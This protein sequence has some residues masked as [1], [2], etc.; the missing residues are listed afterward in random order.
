MKKLLITTFIFSAT[1]NAENIEIYDAKTFSS[2]LALTGCIKQTNAEKDP[3][4]IEKILVDK[5]QQKGFKDFSL[6]KLDKSMKYFSDKPDLMLQYGMQMMLDMNACIQDITAPS[7][8]KKA[9]KEF[10]RTKVL[11]LSKIQF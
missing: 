8:E 1:V 11:L 9:L 10:L 3:V 5:A 4:E 2:V 7:F 6:E